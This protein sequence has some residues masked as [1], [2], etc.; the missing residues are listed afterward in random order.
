MA[1]YVRTDADRAQE[2]AEDTTAALLEARDSFDLYRAMDGQEDHWQERGYDLLLDAYRTSTEP[3]VRDKIQAALRCFA[4]AEEYERLE[5]EHL[6][7]GHHSLL[8]ALT[9]NRVLTGLLDGIRRLAAWAQG[10]SRGRAA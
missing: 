10:A 4:H 8:E 7:D 2:A 6:Q 3:G 5:E 9:H 1:N